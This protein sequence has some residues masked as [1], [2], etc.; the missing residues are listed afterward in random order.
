MT[1]FQDFSYRAEPAACRT[2]A[3]GVDGAGLPAAVLAHVAE[4]RE[5]QRQNAGHSAAGGD[6]EI[7]VNVGAAYHD[8]A[9]NLPCSAEVQAPYRTVR[10]DLVG[11]DLDEI[12]AHDGWGVRPLEA[13]AWRYV[14]LRSR[15]GFNSL[16]PL[17]VRAPHVR[18]IASWKAAGA[19]IADLDPSGS[20]AAWLRA[21]VALGEVASWENAGLAEVLDQPGLAAF[22]GGWGTPQYAADLE[23]IWRHAAAA[24]N[25]D[26]PCRAL[27]LGFMM[28]F[29]NVCPPAL[30]RY[31]GMCA[32]RA[33]T[34]E[35]AIAYFRSFLLYQNDRWYEFRDACE[36]GLTV[37]EMRMRHAR[38]VIRLHRSSTA[39]PAR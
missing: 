1:D 10:S 18:A 23:A 34:A 16:Q 9:D 32:P 3:A 27:E 36:Q 19:T 24:G 35:E 39:E 21:G 11:L 4:L 6:W 15:P 5:D 7:L 26:G 38:D 33:I 22:A 12:A 14:L 29:V 25:V 28:L 30:A 17:A 31:L 8:S 20:A 2:S 13:V 37:D